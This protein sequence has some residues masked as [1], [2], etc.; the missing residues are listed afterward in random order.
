MQ[1]KQALI[2]I[3]D[4]QGKLINQKY[5][6]NIDK[7]K[8]VLK[9]VN[10]IL[11]NNENEVFMIQAND[12]L[13]PGKWGGSCAGLVRVNET[14]ESTASRTLKREL[15]ITT[16][17]KKLSEE[18]KDFG[19]AKRIFSVFHSKI[20]E[21]PS[22]NSNDILEGKWVSFDKAKKMIND[23]KCMP[24]FESAFSKLDY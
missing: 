12:G 9:T 14:D 2:G 17:L 8:D 7:R 18:Y 10:I 22:P 5:R 4:K 11:T 23:N 20:D 1:E 24:T 13:W 15:C 3:Y 19:E 21:K 6:K 16:S